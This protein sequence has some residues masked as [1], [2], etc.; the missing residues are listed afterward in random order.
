MLFGGDAFV[1]QTAPKLSS[2][3]SR[4]LQTLLSNLK[5]QGIDLSPGDMKN[6]ND[7]LEEFSKAET[8]LLEYSLILAEANRLSQLPEYKSQDIMGFTELKNA[9]RQA[10]LLMKKYAKMQTGFEKVIFAILQNCPP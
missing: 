3:V 4:I 6:L 2:D 1:P 7:K 9:N 10:E 8:T 5:S